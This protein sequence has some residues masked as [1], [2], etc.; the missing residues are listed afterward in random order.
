MSIQTAGITLIVLGVGGY[1]AYEAFQQFSGAN[2]LSAER[3]AAKLFPQYDHVLH[4]V[5]AQEEFMNSRVDFGEATKIPTYTD[6]LGK[7]Y[8][9][10]DAPTISLVP[11]SQLQRN[12]HMFDLDIKYHGPVP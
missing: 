4:P 11:V 12:P 10:Q 2:D 8:K 5:V 6:A 1:L 9:V 7:S 3:L